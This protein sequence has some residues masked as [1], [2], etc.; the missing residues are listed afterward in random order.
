MRRAVFID[1]DGV[2]VQSVIRNGKPTGPFKREEFFM[3]RDTDLALSLMRNSGFLRILITNQSDIA[4]GNITIED[5]NWIH[6]QVKSL[7]LDDI[8]ICFHTTADNCECKKPKPGM[9]LH[10]ARKWNI[11]VSRSYMIGD[12]A[13]DTGTAQNA[14]CKSIL[15]VRP[16]N[17]GVGADYGAAS[18]YEAAILISQIEGGWKK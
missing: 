2:I 14:G 5:W 11:D 8:F 10:A 4:L 13:S 18:L 1:R 9:I 6:G 12:T 3:Y 17:V 16:Y 15:L 7:P